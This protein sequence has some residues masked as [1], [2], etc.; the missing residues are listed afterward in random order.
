MHRQVDGERLRSYI[1]LTGKD[2][3][4]KASRRSAFADAILLPTH[5][6][7]QIGSGLIDYHPYRIRGSGSGTQ[8]GR[9]ILSVSRAHWAFVAPD[10]SLADDDR[11]NDRSRTAD[12]AIASFDWR[13]RWAFVDHQDDS[14]SNNFAFA[15]EAG[16]TARTL[17]V[18]GK[19]ARDFRRAALGTSSRNFWGPIL[20]F[21]IQ[22]RQVTAT[23]D[24]PLL[25]VKRKDNDPEPGVLRPFK[26][27]IGFR[28]DAPFFT[29]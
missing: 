5:A 29:F 21:E 18:E 4:L 10:D 12:V 19:D 11:F 26:P 1:T 16:F 8:G 7:G 22:L 23:I 2:D 24:A 9:A 14:L 25:I 20:A 3:T 17:S 28:F 15:V 13:Y 27:V 6:A